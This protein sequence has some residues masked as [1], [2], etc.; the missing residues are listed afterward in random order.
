MSIGSIK[1]NL[2]KSCN[3][4]YSDYDVL[5]SEQNYICND[6]LGN[7]SSNNEINNEQKVFG[8]VR[9]SKTNLHYDLIKKI[10]KFVILQPDNSDDISNL[11]RIISKLSTKLDKE[12]I[13]RYNNKEHDQYNTLLKHYNDIDNNRNNQSNQTNVINTLEEMLKTNT[14]KLVES[15]YT[16]RLIITICLVIIFVILLIIFIKF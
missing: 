1:N 9:N 3:M 15:S 7:K 14:T 11:N 13:T 6:E 16:I 2:V 4:L 10:K 5:N 8:E 12:L